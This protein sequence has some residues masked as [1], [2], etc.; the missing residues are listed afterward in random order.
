MPFTKFFPDLKGREELN[1][2]I[3]QGF[4]CAK[5]SYQQ[6]LYLQL[7]VAQPM[8]I[9]VLNTSSFV[10]LVMV[11]LMNINSNSTQPAL[12]IFQNNILNM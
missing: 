2:N 7:Q 10:I 12:Y 5:L 11:I 9:V 3:E 4:V 8:S 6:S 1:W